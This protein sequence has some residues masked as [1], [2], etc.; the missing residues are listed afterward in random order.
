MVLRF[1]VFDPV[2]WHAASSSPSVAIPAADN[3]PRIQTVI[4]SLL[5]EG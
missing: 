1:A 5:P 3:D 4:G 2:D